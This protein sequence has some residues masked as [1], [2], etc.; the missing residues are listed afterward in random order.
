MNSEPE[1]RLSSLPD[2]ILH[3][4]FSFID[5]LHLIEASSLSRRWRR[6][7]TSAPT[8]SF[9][10]SAFCD[11]FGGPGL[12]Y[13][14]RGEG[15]ENRFSRLIG[16][17]LAL[18]D[19]RF[20]VVELDFDAG[21]GRVQSEAIEALVS[22]AAELGVQRIALSGDWVKFCLPTCV[23]TTRTLK[24]LTLRSQHV[25]LSNKLEFPAL[26]KLHLEFLHFSAANFSCDIISRCPNLETLILI[27]NSI[28]DNT[29]TF[30]ITAP[31]LTRLVIL[32]P[33]E[34]W[35]INKACEFRIHAPRLAHVSYRGVEALNCTISMDSTRT[36]NEVEID[37]FEGKYELF[38]GGLKLDDKIHKVSALIRIL[39]V[40]KLARTIKLSQPTIKI[41]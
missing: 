16:S 5:S 15:L 36:L 38:E 37:V 1:D 33:Y 7:H 6:L 13:R 24:E 28:E 31:K 35:Y 9:G 12:E 14:F 10:Y 29:K 39:D 18:R 25:K 22:A 8:L 4:V 40:F 34:L 23:Y 26:T 30:K 32:Y 21:D 2:D 17:C 27:G 11:R 20:P 41:R 3:H 19:R